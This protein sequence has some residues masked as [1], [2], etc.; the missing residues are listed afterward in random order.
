[1]T[2]KKLSNS[3][4]EAL[5]VFIKKTSKFRELEKKA[6]TLKKECD[7]LLIELGPLA[8]ENNHSLNNGEHVVTF[9]LR[10]GGGFEMP[11]WRKYTADK[12]AK[13]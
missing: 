10:S 3:Q 9:K 5:T 2:K 8:K 4:T 7:N 6:R 13:L 1:M 11:K 12:I